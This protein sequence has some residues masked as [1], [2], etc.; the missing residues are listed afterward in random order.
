MT[1][2]EQF[3]AAR[4]MIKTEMNLAELLEGDTS[5]EID[6]FVKRIRK[7]QKQAA[8]AK[9]KAAIKAV[10][11][12]ADLNSISDQVLVVDPNATDEVTAQQMLA[13]IEK[14]GLSDKI[15]GKAKK[16]LADKKA[17]VRY[18][19]VFKDITTGDDVIFI[20]AMAG[21]AGK[22]D[23]AKA[24]TA[25]VKA[26]PEVAKGQPFKRSDMKREKV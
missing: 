6:N 4:E 22:S 25:Y 12:A 1:K 24:I 9:D 7:V 13:M 17:T 5:E 19:F 18:K 26:Q 20:G 14:L 2:T 16:K 21:P 10:N 3:N 8:E 15:L 23:A 11:D